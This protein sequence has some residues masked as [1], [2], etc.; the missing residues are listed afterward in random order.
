M[1]GSWSNSKFTVGVSADD[2]G[3]GNLTNRRVI[4][5]NP[6]LWYDASN[7]KTIF[8]FFAAHYPQ[9]TIQTLRAS[10]AAD[11]QQQVGSVGSTW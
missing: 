8:Q 2:A 4:V 7:G 10:S 6:D 11:L 9:V 1:N 3:I 5:V